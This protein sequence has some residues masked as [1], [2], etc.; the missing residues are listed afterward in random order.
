[1][2]RRRIRLALE[3]IRLRAGRRE[4]GVVDDRRTVRQQVAEP[5]PD[6]VVPPGRGGV[7]AAKATRELIG[8]RLRAGGPDHWVSGGHARSSIS[9]TNVSPETAIGAAHGRRLRPSGQM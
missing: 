1:M 3:L 7:L 2:S 5:G 4:A 8:P 9:S 6:E